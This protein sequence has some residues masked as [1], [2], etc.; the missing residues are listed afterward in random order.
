MREQ[1]DCREF[2]NKNSRKGFLSEV[3]LSANRVESLSGGLA[4]YCRKVESDFAKYTD[5]ARR[6][7]RFGFENKDYIGRSPLANREL[8]LQDLVKA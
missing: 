5:L 3:R 2:E 6:L 8:R 7:G 1:F 4:L